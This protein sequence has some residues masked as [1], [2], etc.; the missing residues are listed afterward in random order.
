MIPASELAA[1]RATAT[2][3]LDVSNV[4]IVRHTVVPDGYG[5]YSET[6]AVIA[7]VS[8]TE[9]KPTANVMQQYAAVIGTAES[10]TMRFP[11]GT[12]YRNGDHVVMPNGDDRI[13][14]ADLSDS[15]YSTAMLALV[16]KVK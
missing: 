6:T 5:T 11:Y 9:A 10:W 12:S 7:T 13:I 1:L 15:S 16:V 2:S 8:A 4:Q 14:Q 3:A